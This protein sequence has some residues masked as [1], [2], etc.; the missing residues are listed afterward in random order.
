MGRPDSMAFAHGASI[1]IGDDPHPD[2]IEAATAA[3]NPAAQC[4]HTG[5]ATGSSDLLML[6]SWSG[7]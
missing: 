5:S 1:S 7:I 4:T 6:S 2:I 3:R